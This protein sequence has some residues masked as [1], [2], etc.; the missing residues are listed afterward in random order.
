MPAEAVWDAYL[1]RIGLPSWPAPTVQGVATLVLHHVQAIPFENLSPLL[2]QPVSLALPDLHRKL[3]RDQRGGYCYEHNLLFGAALRGLGLRVTDLA[4]RV[5]WTQPE[6]AITPRTHMLLQVHLD[7]QP[8]IVDVGFGAMTLTGVLRLEPGV[9]RTPH[10]D[11]RLLPEDDGWRMQAMVGNAW[12]TLYRYDLHPQELPDY[13]VASYYVSTYPDSFFTQELLAARPVP[14]ARLAL[15]NR[16]YTRYESDGAVR[17]R[18]LESAAQLRDVLTGDFGIA[19]PADE[20]LDAAL[21]RLP[22]HG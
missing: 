13:E 20:G 1:Q 5:L 10:G 22:D 19:L 15:R 6:D 11:F 8:H 16:E 7:G 3:V 12:R 4:A 21:D 9:Q 2:R 17:R 18:R 14:G